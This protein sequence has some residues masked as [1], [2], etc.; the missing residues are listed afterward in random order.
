MPDEFTSERFFDEWK[1]RE[2][3]KLFL[4]REI[5][6]TNS[7]LLRRGRKLLPLLTDGGSVSQ[8]GAEFHFCV[9]AAESQS[10]GRGRRGRTFCSPPQ[11]GAYFSFG[12]VQENGIQNPALLTVSAAVGVCR[13]VEALS[14]CQ[15]TIKW[16][17]DVYCGGK[18]ICGI[19]TEGIMN[20]DSGKIEGAVVGIGI[21]IVRSAFFP[22]ELQKKAGG[23]A[24]G[25]SMAEKK[26][27]RLQ[28]IAACLTEIAA[29]LRAENSCQIIAEYK[30]RSFLLGK[31]ISVFPVAGNGS[32]CFRATAADITADARLLVHLSD[33]TEKILHSGEVTL[34]DGLEPDL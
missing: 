26:I 29:L 19:L 6:S 27:G 25:H 4:F 12:F 7:E 8:N 32:G 1:G 17:N 33:G 34:H 13:A 10:A 18:K 2:C 5:D 11:T 16:V 14:G 9:A 31:T 20:P 24:D 22:P 21:N 30:S 23:I 15:C 3:V 28:L